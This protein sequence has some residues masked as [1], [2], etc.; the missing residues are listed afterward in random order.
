MQKRLTSKRLKRDD[1]SPR[2]P[3]GEGE[4]FPCH[5]GGTMA[6]SKQCRDIL[7]AE[8][9]P[10]DVEMVREAVRQY[11]RLSWHI[12]TVPDGEAVLAF[13]RREGFYSDTPRP[14]LVILDIGLPKLGGWKVLQTLRAT[15]TLATLP[16]VML[17]GAEMEADERQ[18]EVL[19]PLA[20]WVKPMLLRE[21]QPLVE[22]LEVLLEKLAGNG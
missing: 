9:S 12:H 6:A 19:R 20:Y 1:E 4:P 15:P 18:R 22:E 7:L 5:G 8:D 11:G 14:H 21:Y 17:T 13:L 10:A 2:Q 3:H 16:V